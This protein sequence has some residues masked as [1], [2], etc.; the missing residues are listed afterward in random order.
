MVHNI[1]KAKRIHGG[2]MLNNSAHNSTSGMVVDKTQR[3][4]EK[5]DVS[6]LNGVSK[7]T[8]MLKEMDQS[9]SNVKSKVLSEVPALKEGNHEK[10]AH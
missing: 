10:T 6:P 3:T 8:V 5:F 1:N 2:M 7:E 9:Q 4:E